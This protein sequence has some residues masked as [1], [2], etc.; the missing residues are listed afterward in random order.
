MASP[1]S[2]E[3]ALMEHPRVQ[4]AAA[5]GVEAEYTTR[6]KA[7]V[8]CRREPGQIGEELTVELQTW[9]KSRLRQY[10][11]PYFIEFVDELSRKRLPGRSIASSPGTSNEA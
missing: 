5:I 2:I 6:V 3:A 7:Y 8:V 1:I 9:C 4:K 11:Y 10:E